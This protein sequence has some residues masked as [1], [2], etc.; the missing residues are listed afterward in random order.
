MRDVYGIVKF[1]ILRAKRT[2]FVNCQK[3]SIAF[4]AVVEI[5]IAVTASKGFRYERTN[6]PPILPSRSSRD[7]ISHSAGRPWQMST[8]RKE[9]W[10]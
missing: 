6:V 3:V 9:R 4:G 10:Q 5:Q 1:S 2:K 7:R 8:T